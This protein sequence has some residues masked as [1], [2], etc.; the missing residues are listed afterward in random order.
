MQ[1]VRPA[2]KKPS[3]RDRV[4]EGLATGRPQVGPIQVHVDVTNRCNA[5]CITCWDHSPL[6]KV[7]RTGAWKSR[8]L[9]WETWQRLL[10]DLDAFES[11][12]AVVLSGMGEPLTHPRIYDMMADVKAR[13]WHLTVLSN[14]LAAD[15]DRLCDAGIDNLLVG[16]HGAT[17]EAYAAFHPGWDESDFFRMTRG[18]KALAN[19]GVRTRHVQ[20]INRDTAPDVPAMVRFGKRFEADRVNYKLASLAGGTE[21]CAITPEQRRWLVD[22]AV[23]EART[24]SEQLGVRTNLDLFEQQLAAAGGDVTHVTAMDEV[25]CAMG[26]AYTRIAVDGTVLF[27]C[28]TEIEV[29]RVGEGSLAEQWYGPRWQDMRE[30]IG[31]SEWFP[32]CARCGKFEQN[33]KWGERQRARGRVPFGASR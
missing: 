8:R 27:C 21:D 11:V 6:L 30:R 23:P 15:L 5:A 20:V 2:S 10:Q 12:G 16:V 9:P 3:L 22:E 29:G 13:G 32:G 28:N 1:A 26:F 14:L 31:R 4:L 18:L 24:L 33:V 17:P 25:G 7:A 19:A